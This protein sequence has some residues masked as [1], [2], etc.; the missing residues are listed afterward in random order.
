[1]SKNNPFEFKFTSDAATQLYQGEA[2]KYNVAELNYTEL[3]GLSKKIFKAIT[4]EAL[5]ES[6]REALTRLN[7]DI[8]QARAE[9]SPSTSNDISRMTDNQLERV[10][11]GFTA[12]AQSD[13]E[14]ASVSGN[15]AWLEGA[16]EKVDH[17][18]NI[19][20]G[21]GKSFTPTR[22][23]EQNTNARQHLANVKVLRSENG[24]DAPLFGVDYAQPD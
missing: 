16:Q 11:Q 7:V 12:E 8:Q 6:Q 23:A 1:M 9:L 14:A 17:L 20:N 2:E 18:N 19:K 13:L 22:T 24:K 15:Q 5:D 21:G 3:E 10:H 4:T